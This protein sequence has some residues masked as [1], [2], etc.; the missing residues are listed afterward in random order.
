MSATSGLIGKGT[1]LGY[2]A[3]S[4][5][6]YT[7]LAEVLNVSVPEINVA[8]VEATHYTSPNNFIDKKSIVWQ[9]VND[10]NIEVNYTANDTPT[11][12]SLVGTD[13]YWKITL[14]DSHTFTFP[15]FLSKLGAAIPNKDMVKTSLGV[16]VTGQIVYA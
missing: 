8:H 11:L 5:G 6:T 15:G 7:L 12:Y 4:G 10:L 14:S 9:D 2:S 3:T 16:T 13:K 1:T